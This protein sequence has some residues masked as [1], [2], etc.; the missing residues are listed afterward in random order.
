LSKHAADQGFGGAFFNYGPIGCLHASHRALDPEKSTPLRPVY[1]HK[2]ERF[3]TR[4]GGC[5][6][7]YRDLA[8]D[9]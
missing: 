9:L 2:E 3:V 8:Y 1:T 4:W 5:S 7:G 6:I